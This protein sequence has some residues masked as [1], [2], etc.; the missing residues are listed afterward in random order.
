[1]ILHEMKMIIKF[2]MELDIDT[3]ET[4]KGYHGDSVLKVTLRDPHTRDKID[5]FLENLDLKY[6]N[7]YDITQIRGGA[8][9]IFVGIEDPDVYKLKE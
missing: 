4:F 9:S 1:M 8:Y 5:K 2:V 7:D 6:K 3:L